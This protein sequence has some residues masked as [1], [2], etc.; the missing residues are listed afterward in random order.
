M[1]SLQVQQVGPSVTG[2]AMVRS[3]VVAVVHPVRMNHYE[4]VYI[5]VYIYIFI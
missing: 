4:N 1:E 5:Y 3:S 2:H